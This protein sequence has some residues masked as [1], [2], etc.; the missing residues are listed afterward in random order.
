[1]RFFK[2]L[3]ILLLVL[4]AFVALYQK[5]V[6]GEE[7]P[8]WKVLLAEGANQG[9]PGM[10]AIACVIRN[11]GGGLDGFMGAKRKDLDDFCRRQGKSAISLAKKIERRVFKEGAPDSTFGATHFENVERFGEPYWAKD[12]VKTCK[13]RNHTFYKK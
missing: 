4:I 8:Y 9:E 1:M 10:T 13:I 3:L 12:M 7:I 5:M 11:R 2:I 6:Q